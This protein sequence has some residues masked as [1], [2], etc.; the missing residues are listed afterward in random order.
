LTSGGSLMEPSDIL[1][2]ESQ[3]PVAYN[4]QVR[5]IVE[6][7]KSPEP[8]EICKEAKTVFVAMQYDRVKI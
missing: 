7:G 8:A 4:I 3:R 6:P 1:V 2:C 5:P